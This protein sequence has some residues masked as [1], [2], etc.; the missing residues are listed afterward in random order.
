MCCTHQIVLTSDIAIIPLQAL[1][2][3]KQ[4][5]A[6]LGALSVM[7]PRI[8]A[9]AT[10]L[11]KNDPGAEPRLREAQL[12]ALRG[13]LLASGDRLTPATVARVG[14]QLQSML[15]D[16]GSFVPPPL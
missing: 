3:R 2:V 15:S 13:I 4:A 7:S 8:D 14:P 16:A 6:N 9:L 11:V 5:A 10:D 12:W 1:A